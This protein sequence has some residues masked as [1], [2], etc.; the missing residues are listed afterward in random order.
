MPYAVAHV[1]LTIVIADIYRDYISKKK[2]PMIYVLIAGIAGLMPDL[3][4]P[5]SGLINFVFGTDYNFHRIYTH[6][7]AYAIVFFFIAMIISFYR[8]E[9]YKLLKWNV[10]RQALV[11]F[12]LAMSFGWFIH[13]LL[14]CALAADGYLNL[15]PSVPLTFCPHP[16]SNNAL[17]GLDAI[18]LV[19]WLL[20]EQY[21]HDIKD[22]L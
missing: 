19:L 5:V 4:I 9:D 11:M 15:I 16:F 21:R 2:F 6:S 10:P 7:L 17:A 13:V 14:D 1:I 12:F 20:H 22:Y 8:K 3:D 18:I